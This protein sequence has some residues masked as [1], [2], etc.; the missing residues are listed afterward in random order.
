MGHRQRAGARQ[1]IPPFREGAGGHNSL[2]P[3]TAP[4]TREHA[5]RRDRSRVASG[6]DVK[7]L[8]TGAPHGCPSW[9]ECIHR[10]DATRV[11]GWIC[12][13]PEAAI[14]SRTPSP[15]PWPIPCSTS[16]MQHIG[17]IHGSLHSVEEMSICRSPLPTHQHVCPATWLCAVA[18]SCCLS[19][20]PAADERLAIA[21]P[22]FTPLP[23][24]LTPWRPPRRAG[25]S[26]R[27]EEEGPCPRR[28]PPPLLTLLPLQWL[29][30]PYRG[31][32]EWRP[33]QR[34]GAAPGSV[35][36]R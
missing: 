10:L 32:A 11:C 23:E 36:A 21:A 5:C 17:T 4:K 24:L 16:T 9:W 26:A 22:T 33:R 19:T 8:A 31:Q 13:I 27:P 3:A 12:N 15:P 25:A 34:H 14:K 18:A 6:Q 35:A 2:H 28:S 29:T 1:R 20:A 7:P 30:L